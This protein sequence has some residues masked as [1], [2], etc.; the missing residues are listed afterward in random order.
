MVSP[1]TCLTR[2]HQVLPAPN[3]TFH[4]FTM[5]CQLVTAVL[6]L[7][8]Y[9]VAVFLEDAFV[10]DWARHNYRRLSQ[11]WLVERN[12]VLALAE[13]NRLVRLDAETTEMAFL[14]NLSPYGFK[15][16]LLLDVAL[17]DKFVVAY[18]GENKQLFVFG[19]N[20][21]V[22]FHTISLEA[23]PQQVVP[24][25][26]DALIILDAHNTLLAW[27][28]G[29]LGIL[30][31]SCTSFAV[32]EHKGVQ[33]VF[34]DGQILQLNL[35]EDTLEVN[36]VDATQ[37]GGRV[38]LESDV[39]INAA[40]GISFTESEV[41]IIFEAEQG[42]KA[43]WTRKYDTVS[44][45]WVKTT[46]FSTYV[47]VVTPSMVF[48]YDVGKFLKNQNQKTI[49]VSQIEY[50]GVF[51]EPIVTDSSISVLFEKNDSFNVIDQPFGQPKKAILSSIPKIQTYAT[52]KAIIVDHPTSLSVIDKA[53][54]M[55]EDSQTGSDLFRWLRRAKKHLAQFGRSAVG[56]VSGS[57]PAA[58]IN[59]A[60]S[61]QGNMLGRFVGRLFDTTTTV[62][63]FEN[64]SFGLEKVLV[65]YDGV[66][67]IVLAKSTKDGSLV[68]TQFFEGEND[69]VDMISLHDEVYVVSLHSVQ[70]FLLRTGDVVFKKD[71]SFQI[72]EAIVLETQIDNEELEDGPQPLT[73]ALRLGEE[74]EFLR[75]GTDLKGNQF[76]VSKTD[77]CTVQGYKVS[78]GRL[79]KTWKFNNE[80]EEIITIA[81]MKGSLTTAVG[82]SRGD[83]SLLYKYLNPNL[84]TIVT[85]LGSAIKVTL[86]D[87]A[88]GNTLHV[89]QPNDE[90]VDFDS[91]NVIQADNWVIYSY[92]VKFP[93]V[94]QRIA[95]LDLFT[96]AGNAIGGV[97]SSTEGEYDVSIATVSSKSFIYPEKILQLA[98]TQ[99]K[100][101]ITLR[102]IL[103][104]TETGQLVEIPKFF[105]NSRRI[106]DRKMTAKDYEDEFKM[107]PYEAVIMHNS[108]QVLNHKIQL[109]P[110]EKNHQFLLVKPTSL[111]STVV[112]C[113]VS[114]ENEFCTTVQPSLSYD[115]LTQSFDKFTLLLTIGVLYV[116]YLIT[117]PMV[118]TKKLN[119]K[120]LD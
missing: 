100:F 46:K 27:H 25:R 19:K 116:A 54:H 110:V 119:L 16:G 118:E 89:Q 20:T 85:K 26:N 69:F 57:P 37:F 15:E 52:H 12:A 106:D 83:R 70:V 71:F 108:Y 33:S 34:A 84:I 60:R 41:S 113:L 28:N 120:W 36:T 29:E 117:K 98:A 9:V 80:S 72:D 13:S 23:A 30:I 74:I 1:R 75:P 55:V 109:Q 101:G 96:T 43:V 22:L 32:F 31:S 66:N 94:E 82:I 45:V 10:T 97:K 93:V 95:V 59:I 47:V 61:L 115:R 53:H 111:E 62:A 90:F 51:S 44:S 8:S 92:F 86:F 99:T 24:L 78:N 2:L 112:V 114:K 38:I 5:R 64:D 102:S 56:T 50:D 11:S 17:L 14:I 65:L 68:W 77:A 104:F 79:L 35:S 67:N 49:T 107:M 40:Y 63:E 103:A 81:N 21:G 42:F 48:T 76:F 91:I 58:L 73:I 87:G 39:L 4:N 18:L 7:V 3:L 88:S 6:L 105:L